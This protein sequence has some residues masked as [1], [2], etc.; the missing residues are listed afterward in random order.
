MTDDW[1]EDGM[2]TNV[3]RAVDVALVPELHSGRSTTSAPASHHLQKSHAAS[4]NLQGHCQI[5]SLTTPVCTS[6]YE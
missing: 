2:A 3:S 1:D 6:F 5:S 4:N